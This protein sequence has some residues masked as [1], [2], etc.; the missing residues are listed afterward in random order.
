MLTAL[1]AIVLSV[2]YVTVIQTPNS[3][4]QPQAA[5]DSGGT[6]HLIYFTGKAEAGNLEY[7][8]SKDGGET[9]TDPLKVN[10]DSNTAVAIGTIRGGQ[11]AVSPSGHV[12]VVWLGTSKSP[13]LFYSQKRSTD[14][15]F[16]VQRD[17]VDKTVNLDGGASVA[18]DD[19]SVYVVWH[20][21]TKQTDGEDNRRLWLRASRDVGKT[22]S[23][24]SALISDLGACACCSTKAAVDSRGR[25]IAMYRSAFQSVDRDAYS[26][27][28]SWSFQVS[29]E[30]LDTWR[31]ETCPMSSF[32]ILAS[33]PTVRAWETKGRVVVDGKVLPEDSAKHPSLARMDGTVLCAYVVGSGWQKG[34]V[35]AWSLFGPDGKIVESKKTEEAIPMWSLA[36]AVAVPSRG[37][38]IFK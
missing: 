11:I 5:V 22:F 15:G 9:W 19:A 38:L 3:G 34:G 24:K 8:Q 16:T 25:L 21:A 23:P 36:S 14:Q 10:S 37:Y 6:I 28:W 26:V 17:L 33:N 1:A 29:K 30:K 4:I 32:S 35:L 2:P 27:G 7:V 20:A 31:V 13:G 18:C 12:H